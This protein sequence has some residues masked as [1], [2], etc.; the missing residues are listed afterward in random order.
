MI[1]LKY[2]RE[3]AQE[4]KDLLISKKVDF[5]IDELLDKDKNW[6]ELVLKCD[7]LKATRNKVSKDISK[8]KS[9]KKDASDMIVSMRDTSR[10]IKD[11]DK[12]IDALLLDINE[13]LLYIPNKIHSTV[14]IGD[15]ENDNIVIREFG[16]K[17]K[18]NF[19]IKDHLEL[20]EN[21][22]LLDM[23]RG[24]KISGS[25]FPF[26]VG[27][28][29]KLERSLVSFMID[30]HVANGYTELFPSFLTTQ[31][32]TQVTG[33]LPKFKDDMYYIEKDDLYCISTAEVPVT[34]FHKDEVLKEE[35]LPLK[36]TAYSACF[37][38]EAGS[39]GK[40]TKGL[41]RVHQFNKVELVKFVEP[42][43]SYEELERLVSDAEDILKLLGLHYRVIELNSSDLSFSAAKCYDIEVW[44]PAENKYLEVSS[45]SNFES[46]QSRRG[47]IRYKNESNQQMDYVHTLNGSGIATPRLV[48]AILE[49]YQQEDGS[50]LLPKVLEK[51]FS[52]LLIK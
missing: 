7:S 37:R 25:G 26:Y 18:F 36:Y 23:A 5:N 19:K 16:K 1:P 46:F 52:D 44:S 14:P 4:I 27:R 22:N 3:N 13:S 17:K 24:A 35:D 43:K 10:Q 51:Y 30:R 28:G 15:T 38:R 11:I 47:R 8:L 41:L 39:Y 20:C 6:R 42:K 40:D 50:V 12:E 49:N 21:L 2:I 48:V 9:E 29:A 33:Q 32:T 45:C 34:S 31:D